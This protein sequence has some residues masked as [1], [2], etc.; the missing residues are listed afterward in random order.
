MTNSYPQQPPLSHRFMTV[1]M[2][3]VSTASSVWVVPGFRGRIKK[4]SSV[5]NGAI[6][7]ANAAITVEINGTAVSGGALTITQSGSAAGDVDQVDVATGS[8][9]EFTESDAIEIIT[10]GVSTNTVI[11]TFT[12]ELEAV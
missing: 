3:D 2:A 6:A 9:N 7:T 1:T 5:I 11:A 10:D 12:L 8:T 4:L